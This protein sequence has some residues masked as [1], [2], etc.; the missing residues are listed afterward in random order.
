MNCFWV[1]RSYKNQGYGKALLKTAMED[2]KKQGKNGLATVL[3]T[4]NFIL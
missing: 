1:S 3:G 2:A 4:K